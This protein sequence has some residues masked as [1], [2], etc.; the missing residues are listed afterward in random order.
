MYVDLSIPVKASE[1]PTTNLGTLEGS[2]ISMFLFFCCHWQ[3][4]AFHARLGKK[5]G[6]VCVFWLS[7]SL[8]SRESVNQP[9]FQRRVSC[10]IEQA[11]GCF[12]SGLGC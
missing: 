9:L 8:L 3:L 6:F 10:S 5:R 12:S 1:S 7:F 4:L 2:S 11:S